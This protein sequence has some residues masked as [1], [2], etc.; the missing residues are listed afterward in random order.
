MRAQNP[1]FEHFANTHSL[2]AQRFYNV[3]C[4]GYGADPEQFA[5]AV[6]KGYLPESRAEGCADE[7]KQVDYAYRKL[8]R[9]YVDESLRRKV[10]AESL[11][12]PNVY[13]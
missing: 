2:S 13:K 9:P 7:Y 6:R 1:T 5:D 12:T 10:K 3:V 11:L 4:I 8:I